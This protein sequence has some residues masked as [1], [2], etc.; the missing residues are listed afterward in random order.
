MDE[1]FPALHKA[2]LGVDIEGFADRR[3][4][5]LDQI[6]V[7]NALYRCLR[8]AFARS[9]IP[10]DECY[11]E[12][13]GD[14]ALILV[15]PE[16]PK[17]LLVT[18]F[19]QELSVA[20]SSHNE[21]SG[22]ES[23]VRV[24]VVVHA[25]EVHRDGY[26]V[27]GTAINTAFRLL[28]ASA[29]KRALHD[30]PG[31]VA[32]ITS[33][34]FFEEVIRH[35][36]A[37]HPDTY[38]QVR[39]LVKETD[40][41]AWIRL[42]DTPHVPSEGRISASLPLPADVPQQL[43]AAITAFAGR[44]IELQRL[45]AL[46]DSNADPSGTMVIA[47]IGGMPGIGKS[48]LAVYWAHQIV[49]R[50]PGGQLYA[51]LRGF[52]PSVLP[53]S[54]TDVIRRFLEAFG[55]PSERL[56]GSL[57]AQVGLYRSVL[58]GR[59]VLV[60]LDNARDVEQVR[61]LLPGSP[62]CLV[63]VTSRD[64]LTGL[65]TEGAHPL[66]LDLLNEGDAYELLEHR[67]GSARLTAE[68][69]LAREVVELCGRL[70][71]ALS[72]VAARASTH[73]GF[74]LADIT[75]ELRSYHER[76]DA[77]EG[78]DLRANVRAVF[79]WS[80]QQLSPSTARIFRLLGMHPGPDFAV[81]AAASMAGITM[82]EGR[83]VLSELARLH[84]VT[85]HVAGR[86]AFHDLLRAYA[87]ERA[88]EQVSVYKRDDERQEAVHR[89]LDYYLHTA[90]DASLLFSP[91]RLPLLLDAPQPGVASTNITDRSKAI[92]WLDVEMPVLLALI[93]YADANGF[94]SHVWQICWALNPILSRRGRGRDFTAS[95]RIA[96]GAAQR[97]DDRLAIA[98]ARYMLA[99][100]QSLTKD[101]EGA[102]QNVRQALAM[103]QELG[104]RTNE[105]AALHGLACILEDQNNFEEALTAELDALGILKTVGYRPALATVENTVGWLYAVQGRYQQALKHCRRALLLNRETG[106]TGG[107][108]DAL[109][110]LGNIYFNLKDFTQSVNHYE[111]AIE[112]YREISAP[113]G[114]ST[115]LAGLGEA[116]LAAGHPEVARDSLQE[117]LKILGGLLPDAPARLKI[118]L[119]KLETE[120]S[121]SDSSGLFIDENS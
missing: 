105:A 100:A 67:L 39:V 37:S 96:L 10:W 106:N 44:S 34:W 31:A 89:L 112:A 54:V 71:L 91:S 120:L 109:D 51:N 113:F 47:A 78:D 41:L 14:G 26:G 121:Q 84:L 118:R 108:A 16:V 13:R 62:G 43:P 97:L 6:V 116:A 101:Y 42:P 63:L 104:D 19:P 92:I 17:N 88:A 18:R 65:I 74:S 15:P 95:A 4:T 61:P 94:D 22:A 30:S 29:L 76:L 83:S 1:P 7:R 98:Y 21:I 77:F 49:N 115:S 3:R 53:V 55:I 114:E 69:A 82:V 79:S 48:A 103:F 57:E 36:P 93:G 64:R 102:E 90:K 59:R 9:I 73:P 86:F 11:H 25:G 117:A 12:D 81:A 50:F 110:S 72:I 58:A 32:L 40:E 119:A 66:I 5:N 56:P 2:I 8:T 23:R 87:V 107:A 111:Q 38:R 45:T 24:R 28:E 80:Y 75:A 85:E 99:H 27:V 35:S 20:L 52:D 46:L 33:H 68:P 70:P 60:V